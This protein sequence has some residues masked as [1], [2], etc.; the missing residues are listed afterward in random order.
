MMSPG[1]EFDYDAANRARRRVGER[2]QIGE[3]A[4]LDSFRMPIALRDGA[5]S[6]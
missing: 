4:R 3:L 5:R 1:D 2:S 6:A